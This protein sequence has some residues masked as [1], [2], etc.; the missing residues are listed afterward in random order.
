[1]DYSL[2]SMP[3]AIVRYYIA[4][5]KIK[6][7]VK[8]GMDRE[9]SM[10][11]GQTEF[12]Q[13]IIK[14]LSTDFTGMHTLSDWLQWQEEFPL[15]EV[16]IKNENSTTFSEFAELEVISLKA[17]SHADSSSMDLSPVLIDLFEVLYLFLSGALQPGIRLLDYLLDSDISTVFPV[18]EL[19]QRILPDDLKINILAE[20][21]LMS[22]PAN[23]DDFIHINLVWFLGKTDMAGID[24]YLQELFEDNDDDETDDI[25]SFLKKDYPEKNYIQPASQ[26]S[27]LNPDSLQPSLSEAEQ[28]IKT[29]FEDELKQFYLNQQQFFTRVIDVSQT[30]LDKSDIQLGAVVYLSTP[31]SDF[32]ESLSLVVIK[33]DKQIIGYLK[34]ELSGIL[35]ENV[36]KGYQYSAMITNILSDEFDSD[37]RIHIMIERLNFQFN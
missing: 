21:Q 17:L 6:S 7:P 19:L 37:N 23:R 26:N 11:L 32:D 9:V 12:S 15:D 33:K 10:V 36:Q 16:Q 28:N 4:R 14:R 8:S 25:P 3:V 31:L 20:S 18:R 1:M 34:S 13:L 30:I 35:L 2:P 24:R 27:Q 5:L 29:R 22:D